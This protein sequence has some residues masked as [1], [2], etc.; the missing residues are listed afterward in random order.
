MTLPLPPDDIDRANERFERSAPEA[1]LRWVFDG[2]GASQIAIASA[3]QAEG[4]CVIHM[5]TRIRPD[6]PILFLDTGFHF[7]ETLAFKRKLTERLGLN[8]VELTG[9]YTPDMQAREFGPRL[10]ERDPEL[11][12]RL[13]KV[14]PFTEALHGYDAWITA[15]RRDSAPTRAGTPIVEQ[16]ELEPGRWMLK[17]NP[18]ATWNRRDAWSY[19]REHDLPNNPLYDLGYAQVGCAPCTR[20]VVAGEDERAGRWD[21]AAKVE[22]G[23]HEHA[24]AGRSA[25]A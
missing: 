12:C 5:A 4:V 18:I 1:V 13:N 20:L 15:L 24:R 9:R 3:F 2:S 21:G 11:C 25:R 17:A 14:E 16:Y 10:Y 23:I 19:L 8:V 6:V 22:C 7:E